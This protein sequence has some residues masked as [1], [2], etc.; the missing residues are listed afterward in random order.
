MEWDATEDEHSDE[1]ESKACDGQMTAPHATYSN[2]AMTQMPTCPYPQQPQ[3]QILST[4]FSPAQLEMQSSANT[5]EHSISPR[6]NR[7]APANYDDVWQAMGSSTSPKRR[8]QPAPTNY[9]DPWQPVGNM[10]DSSAS[11]RRRAPTTGSY[12]SHLQSLGNAVL[13]NSSS[14]RRR[15]PAAHAGYDNQWQPCRG[16]TTIEG[17]M[18][19]QRRRPLGVGAQMRWQGQPTAI[20][21]ADQS[22]SPQRRTALSS[23]AQA[24]QPTPPAQNPRFNNQ[25]ADVMAKLEVA[26]LSGEW[27]LDLV[28]KKDANNFT[29]SVAMKE[30]D[31]KNW[32]LVVEEAQEVLLRA[33]KES[34]CVYVLGYDNEPFKKLENG[35]MATLGEMKDEAVAC[36]DT[37]ALGACHQGTAC[38]KAHPQSSACV[39]LQLVD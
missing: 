21:S 9:E 1:C 25:A 6:R 5:L 14:P 11:P 7:T 29:V 37:Y 20:S 28:I 39:V 36:W 38:T 4:T 3:P 23:K 2:V 27:D 8:P 19:P 12:H 24:W 35:F 32:S 31:V 18:S 16:N 26:L 33:A 17:S 34:S 13:D 22:V 15:A 10:I 30:E